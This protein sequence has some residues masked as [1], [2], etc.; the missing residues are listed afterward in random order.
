MKKYL[1]LLCAALMVAVL[2]GCGETSQSQGGNTSPEQSPPTM[3]MVSELSKEEILGAKDGQVVKKGADGKDVFYTFN[4]ILSE[5]F[6][7]LVEK[8]KGTEVSFYGWGGDEDLNNWLDNY[9]APR[10]K[11]K[12]DIT[13]KRVPMGIEDI[14][15]QMTGE[16]QA[17]GIKPVNENDVS[18]TID[19]IWVNG[20][21]FAT[22][23][24]SNM[25]LDYYAW[26]APNLEKYMKADSDKVNFDFGFPIRGREIPY[27]EAQLVMYS[28]SA[29]D[30]QLPKSTAELMEF[31]KK[32]PGKVTYPAL[33][34]FTGSAF[35]RNVI[36]DIVGYE[37][38]QT[39]EPDKAKVKEAIQPA[40][41]Y[42]KELNPYLWNEGKTFPSSSTQMENMF[43]DGELNFGMSY[44]A[45][46]VAVNIENQ[47]FKPTT[48]TF[49]FDKGM[50]GNTNYIAIPI[51]SPNK[52]GAIV[53]INE[54]ISPE[55]Q[56]ERF[57]TLRTLPVV[58][59]DML[60]ED[61]QKAFDAVDIGKGVLPQDELLSKKLP[62]M[63]AKLVPIIEEIWLEEVVGK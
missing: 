14:L 27:G 50:V 21:N 34:D 19:M 30:A 8:A 33:P 23:S 38:F 58:D 56:A 36:Y 48:Q 25:L 16:L 61:Q 42:L 13:I 2:V 9:Y 46:G 43:A 45:Y 17:G 55:V 47:K 4:P 59:Y 53:A 11:E 49:L 26:K 31:A 37:Q 7:K 62:E 60:S 44:A 39:M 32:H 35:V 10:M 29:I 22:A 51:N 20:E 41:D 40:L 5:D 57:K 52:A 3:G 1:S 54:M 28:D 12:Y 15:S 18:G 24:E 6:D 63:P